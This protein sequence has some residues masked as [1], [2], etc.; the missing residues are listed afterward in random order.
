MRVG[1]LGYGNLG[2]ALAKRIKRTEHELVAIFSRRKI[3][4]PNLPIY[5]REAIP[6]FKNKLHVL[7]IA[8]SSMTDA[9]AD[10]TEYLRY[11]ST[12]DSLDLHSLIPTHKA[13]LTEIAAAEKRV[14][15]C[16][17]GWDPGVLSIIRAISEV[18]VGAKNVNTFWGIGKSLG[19]TTAIKGIPGVRDGVQYTVPRRESI[20]LAKNTDAPLSATDRHVRECFIVPEDGVDR[21]KIISQIKNMEGYFLGYETYVN[22]IS[23][24]EFLI[25]HRK[26][27]HRGEVVA[28]R[29]EGGEKTALDF[30][31]ETPS[32][33]ILTADIM[34]S[35]VTAAEKLI[36]NRLFGAYTPLDIPMSYLLGEEKCNSII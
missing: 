34:L 15:I 27:L 16:G 6:D 18:A 30:T 19:H 11:F 26:E 4:E 33:P 29:I 12:V 14:A 36:K 1:I 23:E 7:I 10:S 9:M 8:T 20:A 24:E 31:L 28:T 22:F 35:Y 3:R 32:N 25:N 2:A 5:E 21:E 13:R 17:A